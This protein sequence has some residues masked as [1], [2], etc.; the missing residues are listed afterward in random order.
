MNR[1]SGLKVLILGGTGSMGVPLTKILVEQGCRVFVT[2]R[3]NISNIPSFGVEYI[4]GNAMDDSFLQSTLKE[5]Y[6]VVVDFM[7]YSTELFEK[8]VNLLL[9]TTKQ[10]IYL[11]S[12][13]IFDNKEI[14]ITEKTNKLLDVCKDEKF[15]LSD[16][17]A[18]AKA[19]Q[20][21][22]LKKSKQSNW[23][24]VRP[25]ITYNFN[26]IQL[27][28]YEKET[29]LYRAMNKQPFVF[30]LDMANCYTTFTS[31]NDVA[32]AISKLIN[33]PLAICEDFNIVSSESK[34]WSEI[35]EIYSRIFQEYGMNLNI[36]YKETDLDIQKRFP[37]KKY[38]FIFDRNTNRIFDNSK[39]LSIIGDY[40]FVPARQGL[41]EC[42]IPY[43]VGKKTVKMGDIRMQAYQDKLTQSISRINS[44]N[45]SKKMMG[46]FYYRFFK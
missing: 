41:C 29:W 27:G 9:A 45:S 10:Y 6:D 39:I 37:E 3:N 44:F 15:I 22:I 2:T 30:S 40:D 19:K 18:V 17:Y 42:C 35:I 13:R 34:K 46:Y 12:G 16:E 25:Y 1:L 36:V 23:T 20:E 4:Y 14:P 21:I 11:S 32:Y 33:N 31:G 8:R 24:I 26:R 5:N 38:Q 7:S 28:I 43:L